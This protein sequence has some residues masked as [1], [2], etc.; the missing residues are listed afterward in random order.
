M[1]KRL[2]CGGRGA[3]EVKEHDFFAPID[4]DKL[5]AMELTPPFEP[6]LDVSKPTRQRIPKEQLTLTLTPTLTP[7]PTATLTCC[8]G[9]AA[10]ARHPPPQRARAPRAEPRERRPAAPL[11][12]LRRRVPLAPLHA[13][14]LQRTGQRQGALV[15]S[16]A[17]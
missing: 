17:E 1:A 10:L 2:A 5:M 14:P 12:A 8:S 7:A 9:P 3:A 6:D 15:R 13:R 16:R 4:W 11:A